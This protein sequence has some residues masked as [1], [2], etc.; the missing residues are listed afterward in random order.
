VQLAYNYCAASRHD[1]RLKWLTDTTNEISPMTITPLTYFLAMIVAA[2]G[3]GVGVL[4]AFFAKEELES[5]EKYLSWL[6]KA[7]ISLAAA[8]AAY[9]ALGSW[10]YGVLA[11]AAMLVIVFLSQ[12]KHFSLTSELGGYLM[13]GAVFFAASLNEGGF[14]LVASLIFLYGFPAGS[15]LA[16][17]M[18][19]KNRLAIALV[20]LTRALAF[21]CIASVLYLAKS[22]YQLLYP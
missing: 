7:L 16:K 8:A 5:L 14:A 3:I 19:K 11:L 17:R 22:G 6:K 2:L 4:L 10:I 18:I 12:L 13:L 20:A 9:F 15:L 21:I 1:N